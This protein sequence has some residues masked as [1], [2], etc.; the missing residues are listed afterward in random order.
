MVGRAWEVGIELRDIYDIAT[1]LAFEWCPET[2]TV[3]KGKQGHMLEKPLILSDI[4]K[5][6]FWLNW[7]SDKD[8]CN[9]WKAWSELSFWFIC[10]L[11][12]CTYLLE[13]DW[14]MLC[15]PFCTDRNFIYLVLYHSSWSKKWCLLNVKPHSFE[16]C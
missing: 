8:F 16:S 9:R 7:D 14:H 6:L 10:G 11:W 12:C 15:L 4:T 1:W 5:M 2:R 13:C 3:W